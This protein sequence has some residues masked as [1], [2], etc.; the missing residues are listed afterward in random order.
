MAVE[1][2]E[3][4]LRPMSRGRN[5][6]ASVAIA[7]RRVVSHAT[8][9][10]YDD[11]IDTTA[12]VGALTRLAGVVPK[13]IEAG[14]VGDLA[15]EGV[16]PVESTGGEILVG[17]KLAVEQST[18]RVYSIVTTAPAGGTNVHTIGIARSYVAAASAA[19]TVVMMQIEFGSFQG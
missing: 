18:G 10:T 19:G 16:E 8:S 5:I 7:A 9:A 14:R 1:Y 11:A 15:T 6:H 4:G 13:A 17:H 12:N 2:T 3:R